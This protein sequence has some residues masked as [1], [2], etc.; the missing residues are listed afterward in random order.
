VANGRVR[1]YLSIAQLA[2]VTPWTVE[3][4]NAKIKRGEFVRG[5]HY[6]QPNGRRGQVIVKWSAI[7]AF[8]EEQAAG[9]EE[10]HAGDGPG[11]HVGRRV[12]LDVEKATAELQR[13]L[14]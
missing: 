1:E 8:I 3:A 7:V 11:V 10:V 9:G 13:L 4:I 6:F 5:V 12:L 14:G 2:E